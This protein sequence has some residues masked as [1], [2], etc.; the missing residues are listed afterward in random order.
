MGNL[1]NFYFQRNLV[2]EVWW[3]VGYRQKAFP[4][5]I[6]KRNEVVMLCH[7]N[8][9]DFSD[10]ISCW[11]YSLWLR[12][13]SGKWNILKIIG[14]SSL[15]CFRYA[16][17]SCL[18]FVIV[19]LDISEIR[20][21]AVFE[22]LSWLSIFQSVWPFLWKSPGQICNHLWLEDNGRISLD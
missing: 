21:W 16:L 13:H 5:M 22:H 11:F 2:E 3:S 4:T 12:V 20:R 17:H 6:K 19:L 10:W 18:D 9:C 15:A 14:T 8:I 7:C 1:I